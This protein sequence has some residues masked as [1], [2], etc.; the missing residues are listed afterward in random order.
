MKE[1]DKN[2]KDGKMRDLVDGSCQN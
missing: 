1:K 2:K